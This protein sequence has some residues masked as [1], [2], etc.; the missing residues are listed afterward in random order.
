LIVDLT[1]AF[2]TIVTEKSVLSRLQE[3]AKDGKLGEFS[4]DASSI[5][6]TRPVVVTTTTPPISKTTPS[7][8]DGTFPF[9]LFSL[10][11]MDT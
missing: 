2:S 8:S 9:T 7:V 1:L 6:G 3:A 10:I 4:V 5:K 11:S